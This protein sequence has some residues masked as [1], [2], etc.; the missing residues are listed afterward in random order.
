MRIQVIAYACGHQARG[1]AN[2]RPRNGIDSQWRWR[3]LA[4]GVGDGVG[5]KPPLQRELR[6]DGGWDSCTVISMAACMYS[7]YSILSHDDVRLHF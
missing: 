4:G 5:R 3:V 6:G 1:G 2:G 7:A